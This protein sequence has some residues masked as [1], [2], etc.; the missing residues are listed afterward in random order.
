ML[1]S[2]IIPFFN[3][4]K[5]SEDIR[6][7]I[8]KSLK[9]YSD[10]EFILIDDGSID[11]TF[12]FLKEYF[13]EYSNTKNIKIIKQDNSG[14]GAARNNGLTLACGEF[15]WF[16]DSDDS[17]N[18]DIAL[19]E[20]KKHK[21]EFNDFDFI[22][23]NIMSEDLV[24]NSMKIN[25][26]VYFD[27]KDIDM[28]MR[29]GRIVTKIFT[30]KFL[31]NNSIKFMERCFYEDNY[32]IFILPI[33]ITK[34]IKSDKTAYLHNTTYP[35]ITRGGFSEK[36]YDRLLS[37]YAG[38]DYNVRHCK[39]IQKGCLISFYNLFLLITYKH[40]TRGIESK[41]INPDQYKNLEKCFE[42]LNFIEEKYNIK[43]IDNVKKTKFKK[44]FRLFKLK[45]LVKKYKAIDNY[46]YF[47]CMNKNNW[48]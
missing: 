6:K 7:V 10:I 12:Y 47:N 40:I 22:D 31:I 16:V 13:E 20:L 4:F 24:H 38:L 5:F 36:F 1:L 46:N 8:D 26:G 27:V 34:F 25:P 18:L 32:L 19:N 14:P 21:K 42:W 45:R 23:F 9:E 43:Y 2:I 29:L 28:Y 48:K 35:S 41:E 3:S 15:V 44:R 33:Y 11:S 39:S 30:R 37:A 17:I